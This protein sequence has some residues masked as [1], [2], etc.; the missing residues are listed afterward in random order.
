MQDIFECI[1]NELLRL[2]DN[3]LLMEYQHE[4]IFIE[5]K[6]NEYS[7]DIM[8]IFKKYGQQCHLRCR[9]YVQLDNYI[10]DKLYL[11]KYITDKP[12]PY[13]FAIIKNI[14]D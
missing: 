8:T 3:K 9:R 6:D 11:A 2:N 5:Y 14:V 4:Y 10:Q 12:R 1:Y 7:S 13:Y